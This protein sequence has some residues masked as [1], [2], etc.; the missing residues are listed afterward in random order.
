MTPLIDC[1]FTLLVVLMLSAT[2]NAPDSIGLDLPQAATRDPEERQE[3]ILSIDAAGKHVLNNHPIDAEELVDRLRP[4]IEKSDHK[5]VTFR[6]D[7]KLDY[8]TFVKTLDA[9]RAAGAV[10]VNMLHK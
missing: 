6:G 5:V 10:H 3:I 9:V 7:E 1:V 2:F 8:K 4:I